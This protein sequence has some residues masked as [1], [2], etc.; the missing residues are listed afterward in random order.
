MMYSPY[1]LLDQTERCEICGLQLRPAQLPLAK[2][3]CDVCSEKF[4]KCDGCGEIILNEFSSRYRNATYCSVCARHYVKCYGCE[5]TI[6]IDNREPQYWFNGIRYCKHC[7]FLM[8]R[9]EHCG[10]VLKDEEKCDC[11]KISIDNTLTHPAKLKMILEKIDE[12][13]RK[14]GKEPMFEVMRQKLSSLDRST[15]RPSNHK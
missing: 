5:G 9:C 12:N 3:I 2:T 10:A 13:L 14:Y 1:G 15:S 4:T 11:V 7:Y 8:K 6:S